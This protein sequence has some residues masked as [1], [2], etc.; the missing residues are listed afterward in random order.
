MRKGTVPYVSN[1]RRRLNAQNLMKVTPNKEEDKYDVFNKELY[2]VIFQI[3]T[4]FDFL[5]FTKSK[6][7]K[8][9]PVSKTS[10]INK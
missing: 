7:Q 10:F 6:L 8:V 2:R 5:Y 3:N 1:T 4:S 9:E